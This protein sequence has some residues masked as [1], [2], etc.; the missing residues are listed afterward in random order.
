MARDVFSRP[1]VFDA[2]GQG[3]GMDDGTGT[4]SFT[5]G[6]F[7]TVFATDIATMN[8][9]GFTTGNGSMWV[10]GADLP[11]PLAASTDYYVAVI[12]ANTFYFCSSI[13]NAIAA[14]PVPVNLTDNGTPT[15]TLSMLPMFDHKIRVKSILIE[16]GAAGGTF[17]VSDV[18]GG[19][20][21]T[22]SLVLP[23]NDWVQIAVN[24]TVKGVYM[25]AIADGQVIVNLE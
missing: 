4:T 19:R 6:T 3:E 22:G 16:S 11:A 7:T 15:H 24:Q 21:L 20:S 23:A 5:H 10:S 17:E 8:G 13:A 12:D 25:T 14:T 18:S 1:W 2:T 9:H